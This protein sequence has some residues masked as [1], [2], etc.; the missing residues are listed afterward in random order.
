GTRLRR[1]DGGTKAS[2][3]D[4]PA[5]GCAIDGAID[6]I[7]LL[8]Y[9][10]C[11]AADGLIAAEG[12]MVEAGGTLVLDR[13]PDSQAAGTA[14]AVATH[15]LVGRERRVADAQR[16]PGLV[17]DRTAGGRHAG[18]A[19]HLPVG[20]GQVLQGQARPG[21]DV[22]EAE[23]GRFRGRAPGDGV[24]VALDGQVVV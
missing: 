10:G 24:A 20:N 21:G 3:A 11:G 15:G 5:E 14:A 12:I 9:T 2:I 23:R 18:A 6:G 17:Q 22:E 13:A 1:D 16:T 19:D 8:A 4:R 7:G